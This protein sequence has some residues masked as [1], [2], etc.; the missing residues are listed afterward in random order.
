MNIKILL[1]C[2]F[3]SI[4]STIA[5]ETGAINTE[6]RGEREKVSDLVHTKLKV[7][8]DYEKSQM[9]GE[10]WITL[11]PHF[12]NVSE[13]ELDAKAMLI[14]KVTSNGKELK[15]DY[16]DSKLLIKLGNTYG[17][18]E[19]YTVYIEYT[20]RPEEVKELG[21]AAISSAKGL[22]FVD[23]LGTDPK[24][25]TQIWTQGETEASSCWF[26]TIDSPNQKTSQEIYMTVPDQYVT[27]SNGL[28]KEQTKNNDGTRTDYWKF[29]KKHAPYLFF[30]GV[31]EF[32]IVEDKWKDIAVDYYVEKEYEPYAK[33]I[34]GLTPEMLDF[35]S[36]YTGI[37][38]PWSKYA[39]FIGRDYVSG[40]MENTTAVI[41][42]ES[43]YQTAGQLVDENTWEGT[44]AH[45]LFHHWFGDLVTTE[46]WSN[47]TVNESFANYSEYLWYEYKYGTDRADANRNKEI[48]GYM[49]PNNELK[50]LVRFYYNSR[51]DMFD[52]VSYNKG[53]AILHML[54][55]YLGDDAFRAGINKYLNDHL[56]GTGEAHQLRLA[57]EKVSG[58]DL[59]WFFNQWY[60]SNGHPKLEVN[61][62]YSEEAKIVTV[63]IEQTQEGLFQFP[64]AIEV[65][66]GDSPKRYEVWV[67]EKSKSFSFNYTNK[68]DLVNVD[69]DRTLLA[70]FN[71]QK[72]VENLVHLYKVGKKYEDRREAIEGLAS[73]QE[74]KE[75]FKTM[76]DALT[77]SFYGLR[78]MAIQKID[79]VNT[80]AK[81]TVKVIEN[82]ASSDGKTLV[83]AAAITKLAE[84]DGAAYI[85]LFKS[86]LANESNAMKTSA[87]KALYWEDKEA[88]LQFAASI[89][90]ELIKESLK[91]A[92][93]PVFIMD[94]TEEEQAFVA[95]NLLEGMF[96]DDNEESNLYKDGFQWVAGSSNEEATQNLVDAF[97]QVG[98]QYKQYGVDKMSKRILQQVLGVKNES[99]FANKE[100]LA[101]IVQDGLN[102]LD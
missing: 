2:F 88:A 35:Y 38:Y 27:L 58:K 52:A 47:I 14:H 46:S 34:F 5:Q 75:A 32:S 73:Q 77:D 85:D 66:E 11:T 50:D 70:E 84:Y 95:G 9:A 62:V 91:D 102:R 26:P 81:K 60:F 1:L 13:L 40:A 43:A 54:R 74:N 90:D 61:Y 56:Y 8:F 19:E 22:Y 10:A 71:D 72:T 96:S 41:H 94:K 82:M 99:D 69:A 87:L 31:G 25:P 101:K 42:M 100:A 30:M 12:Y 36:D 39:Q 21:S 57:F 59:N 37:E 92:L 89:E 18:G 33:G 7:S 20:A 83:R 97:V 16:D 67:D 64:L 86:S 3:L 29:D 23:P 98:V 45:E 44:I 80:D 63:E 55:S 24:K 78:I 6:Y 51:E 28:L 68:P 4:G 15:Y 49:T 17:K 53:G 79:L 93:I 65:F 48:K 76:Q